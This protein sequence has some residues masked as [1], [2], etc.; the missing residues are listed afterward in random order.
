MKEECNLLCLLLPPP[1]LPT[2][3]IQTHTPFYLFF[4]SSYTLLP[5]HNFLSSVSSYIL[6]PLTTFLPSFLLFLS[7]FTSFYSPYSFPLPPSLF[8]LPSYF[9]HILFSPFPFFSSYLFFPIPYSLPF[10]FSFTSSF[11]LSPY[12]SLPAP[13]FFL[14]TSSLPLS[15]A[16][17]SLP[18]MPFISH[19]FL[20]YRPF[21]S[22]SFSSTHTIFHPREYIAE[23]LTK[24]HILRHAKLPPLIFHTAKEIS[25]S[26]WVFFFVDGVKKPCKTITRL[27]KASARAVMTYP[28][29]STNRWS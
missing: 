6:A 13:F 16:F 22:L 25:S 26:P 14:I 7:L 8:F 27:K 19:P 20:L 23:N 4:L 28:R 17:L 3:S 29:V 18:L 2:Q 21:S 9:L 10:P 11:I 1:L 5:V 24:T 15:S 12:P